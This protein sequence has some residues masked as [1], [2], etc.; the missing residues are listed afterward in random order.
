MAPRSTPRTK[1]PRILDPSLDHPLRNGP[2]RRGSAFR[3]GTPSEPPTWVGL[4]CPS[5]EVAWRG[6]PDEPCWSC[7][8]VGRRPAGTTVVG[9]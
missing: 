6:D 7:G 2:L 8:S 5:C 9:D 3:R 1:D 4:V